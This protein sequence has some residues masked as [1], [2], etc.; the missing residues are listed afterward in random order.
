MQGVS[1][2]SETLHAPPPTTQVTPITSYPAAVTLNVLRDAP[3]W[4]VAQRLGDTEAVKLEEGDAYAIGPGVRPTS[5]LDAINMSMCLGFSASSTERV[6]TTEFCPTGILN[7]DIGHLNDGCQ[8]TNT[9]DMEQI[10]VGQ[11]LEMS[12]EFMQVTEMTDTQLTVKR[13]ILDTLPRPHVTGER[14]YIWEVNGNIQMRLRKLTW[15]LKQQT[16]LTSVRDSYSARHF[17]KYNN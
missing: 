6:G 16:L 13:G 3:C 11:Y 1:S 2:L 7:Q 17:G 8:I 14:F 10:E 9:L 5:A 12:G 4:E 15:T